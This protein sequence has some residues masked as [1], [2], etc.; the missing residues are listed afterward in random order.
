V[1]SLRARI[2][3]ILIVSI[4]CVVFLATITT[5]TVVQKVASGAILPP[6]A[7]QLE[8][9]MRIAEDDL[10]ASGKS[11]F[12]SSRP[13]DGA[14]RERLTNL[15][16]DGFNRM[17]ESRRIIVTLPAGYDKPVASIE[18]T[19]DRWLTVPIADEPN[20]PWMI[21]A[22]W[23]LLIV[24]GTAG[25]SLIVANRVTR[26]LALLEAVAAGVGPDGHLQTVAETGP[27]EVR[28]TARAL[29]QMNNKLR[30]AVE[31]RMRLVAAA[32]HDLRT[33]M[34]R[35]RLRA[36]FL[37]DEDRQ[38][39]LKDVE[40][41]DRI[42]D[43]AIRL[44]REEV[45]NRDA[46]IV[47]LDAMARSISVELEEMNLPVVVRSTAPVHI[48]GAPLALTRAFR[49][50][51]INAAMH[52]GGA[53]I[54]VEARDG[55]AVM[56]IED[57]GP[58]IPEE[59]LE[60]VFEPFFRVDPSRRQSV[61]GAGL[62]LAIAREIIDRAGGELTLRSRKGGGLRQEAIFT[63]RPELATSHIKTK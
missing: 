29:N 15:L 42:A 37:E 16:Q 24:V 14:P 61:P 60:Q 50:L 36:E 53:E 26:S 22:A 38:N 13:I 5:L 10:P 45:E 1:N 21:L 33:P 31:S 62:G 54:A 63:Q 52:G 2:A 23:M 40:E 35:M 44:V 20:P 27:A 18:L 4:T 17:G 41:L 25:I 11:I 48:F 28:A 49:N 8:L 57:R 43:S 56:V 3:A 7:A 34:T 32:G 55:R 9:L 59:L 12:L 58:G 46:E 51:I 6:I 19:R 47:W 30:K 39:W